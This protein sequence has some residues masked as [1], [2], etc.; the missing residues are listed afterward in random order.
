MKQC[1]KNVFLK[2]TNA[3]PV[4]KP[5]LQI[6]LKL[7]YLRLSVDPKCLILP[8][9]KKKMLCKKEVLLKNSIATKITFVQF[10]FERIKSTKEVQK[11]GQRQN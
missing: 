3:P 11:C 6:D 5:V 4:K 10:F 1:I 9:S 2:T 7:F 8:S